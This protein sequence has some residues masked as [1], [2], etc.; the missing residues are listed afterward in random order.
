MLSLTAAQE[1]GFQQ[2]GLTQVPG[3][4]LWW[5]GKGAGAVEALVQP[6]GA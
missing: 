3:P 2:K 5:L 6:D 4:A 1:G